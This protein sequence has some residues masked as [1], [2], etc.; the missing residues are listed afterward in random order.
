MTKEEIKTLLQMVEKSYLHWTKGEDLPIPEAEIY[1][2]YDW[3]HNKAPFGLLVHNTMD[4]PIYI[5]ANEF[6]QKVFGY[7]LDE[8][9]SLPS[10]LNTLPSGQA[11]RNRLLQDIESNGIANGY[12]GMRVSKRGEKFTISQGIIWQVLDDSGKRF[13]TAAMVRI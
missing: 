9:L 10:R 4:D 6:A 11:D 8:F 5:Y 1:H 13:G 2:K 3:L 7:T 12:T